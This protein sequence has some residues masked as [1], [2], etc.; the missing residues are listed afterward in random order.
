MLFVQLSIAMLCS[1]LVLTERFNITV[2]VFNSDQTLPFGIHRTGPAV[3]LGI[4]KLKEI[5]G[6]NVK[7]D[8][9][10]YVSIND[11]ECDPDKQGLF[12]K[13][14]SEMHYERNITA[15]I[16][17][18]FL[19][20]CHSSVLREIMLKAR[21]LGMTS[22]DYVFMNFFIFHGSINGEVR[23]KMEDKHDQAA[24]EAFESLLLFG[25]YQSQ[26]PDY[27]EFQLQIKQQSLKEYNFDYFH[28]DI[29][30]AALTYYE[31]FV[32][33][34]EIIAETIRDGKDYTDGKY[35]M[36][37][38]WNRT[39][40]GING[41]IYVNPN[42]DREFS[43][44]VLDMNSSTGDFLLKSITDNVSIINQNVATFK[45]TNVILLNLNAN[46]LS[47]SKHVYMELNQLRNITCPN[48]T[49]FLGLTENNSTVYCV[50]ELCPRGDLRDIL[51]NDSFV[52]NREFSFSLM[53][54]IIQAMEY[55]HTS[56]IRY[57]GSLHS[58]NCVID[59]RFV[60]KV[61][62]FGLQSLRNFE[63]DPS[64]EKCFWIAPEILRKEQL[65][66][67]EMQM[68]DVYS[69]GITM[70]EV[71]TRKEPYEDDKKFWS[72][73][74]IL[75]KLKV[76]GG[77]QFRPSVDDIDFDMDV[78]RLMKRCW[79]EDPKY[80]PTF[81]ALRKESRKMHW[82]RSGDKL[83]D[84]LLSRMEQYANNLEEV[85]EERTRCL[86]EEKQKSEELLYQVLPRSVANELKCGRV[87]YPE[88]YTCVTI[89]FSDIVGFTTLSSESTP[90]QVIDLLN[91]LYTCFDTIIEHFDVYKVETIGDAYMVV[92]GLPTRN[93][94][95]HVVEIAKM[96]CSILENVREFKVGHK[97]DY[98]LCARI[99]IHSGPVCAG[100]VGRK[101]PRYCL[102]GDTVNT[103]SRMESNGEAMKIHVSESSQN[104]LKD[105][106]DLLLEERGKIQIKGKGNMRTYWLHRR[107]QE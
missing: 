47:V 31:A 64:D 89:Y 37:R 4:K 68:A 101:M 13:I 69:F 86:I 39:F 45:G 74:E 24:R 12:G 30:P 104:L 9:V 60:L 96:S 79:D 29:N 48:L 5:L 67:T 59:S 14:I 76:V 75:E 44:M 34:G 98:Q 27:Q 93:G 54:D 88:A 84:T 95:Q 62:N 3:D 41:E 1:S 106:P 7:V 38:M 99:G 36:S 70:Y 92:S 32:L 33:Y 16:G 100:V 105:H 103:A 11:S 26:E 77:T 107:L 40:N 25:L 56:N 50:S 42:G 15:I 66:D 28:E 63:V 55:I 18:I 61:A 23:W 10:R 71:I 17:P 65:S 94:D 82:E 35:I 21:V 80:R 22:G 49:K 2:A 57:H 83:L 78:I 20:I 87:V 85:V 81:S 46:S 52:L 51:S 53:R 91:G 19:V 90:M 97:P 43:W 73:K 72:L 8:I 6:E 58:Q 102:F